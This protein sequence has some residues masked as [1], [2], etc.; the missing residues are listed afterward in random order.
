MT[1]LDGNLIEVESDSEGATVTTVTSYDEEGYEYVITEDEN[2]E[3][4]T[5]VTA[6]EDLVVE[7]GLDGTYDDDDATVTSF[8]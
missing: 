6:A 5:V 7:E 4:T 8:A 3:V 2:G 1:D